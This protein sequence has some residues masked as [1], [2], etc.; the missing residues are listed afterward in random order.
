MLLPRPFERELEIKKPSTNAILDVYEEAK[1]GK[2]YNAMLSM[3][4]G[5]VLIDGAKPSTAELKLFPLVNAEYLIVEGFK[6]F[7][8]PTKVEGVYN[9]PRIGCGTQMILEKTSDSDTRIDISELEVNFSE[10][11]NPYEFEIEHK[12]KDVE[13]DKMLF[14]DITLGDMI[15]MSKEKKSTKQ[16]LNDILYRCLQGLSFISERDLSEANV[17][18][19]YRIELFNFEN[20]KDSIR[21]Q[22]LF[23]TYGYNLYKEFKC[24]SCGKEWK[25]AIDFTGFFVYALSYLAGQNTE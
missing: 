22:K 4:Q 11:T 14:R 18:N 5:C 16:M 10:N 8:L 12:F 2:V 23:R 9:C 15:D 21:L 19:Q 6:K 25:Q 7:G 13:I 20:Y 1:N 24:P 3:L 17:K